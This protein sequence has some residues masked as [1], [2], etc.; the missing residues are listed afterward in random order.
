[1]KVDCDIP[2]P[3]VNQQ[4]SLRHSIH[5]PPYKWGEKN[6]EQRKTLDD[7]VNSG[8]QGQDFNIVNAREG[9]SNKWEYW[10]WTIPELAEIY[11]D[12]EKHK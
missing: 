9:Y 4:L 6:P 10:C 7:Y 2:K 8:V 11:Y 3:L 12:E 1:M 5:Y